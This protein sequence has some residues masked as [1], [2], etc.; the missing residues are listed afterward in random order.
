MYRPPHM[1]PPPHITCHTRAHMHV[2]A[3]FNLS[4]SR[5]L[6]PSLPLYIN[7]TLTLT[8]I[9]IAYAYTDRIRITARRSLLKIKGLF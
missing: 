6:S 3:T 8:R 5:A 2:L 1:Y 4:L 9:Q 7:R